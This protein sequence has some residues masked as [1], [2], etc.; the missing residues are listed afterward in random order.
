MIKL[1]EDHEEAAMRRIMMGFVW[2]LLLYFGMLGIGGAV[3]GS[4]AGFRET[5]VDQGYRAGH[6]AG[7]EFGNKYREIILLIA[8]AGAAIGT[9]TGRLPGTKPKA[10]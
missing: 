3:L 9:F 2:S 4:A 1:P 8:V 7:Q 5:H 10:K 6:A